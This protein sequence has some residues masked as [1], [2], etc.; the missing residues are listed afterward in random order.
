LTSLSIVTA[1]TD[2]QALKQAYIAA[3][4]NARTK[5]TARIAVHLLRITQV[6]MKR[7]V[8]APHADTGWATR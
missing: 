7:V 1:I 8:C 4:I 3:K 6:G 2:V 5:K